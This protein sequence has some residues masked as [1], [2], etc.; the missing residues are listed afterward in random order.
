MSEWITTFDAVFFLSIGT[1]FVGLIGTMLKYC[2]KSKC[3]EFNCCSMVQGCSL[4]TVKRRVDLEVQEE[5]H[6]MD[7]RQNPTANTNNNSEQKQSE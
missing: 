4:F 5:L 7:T 1:L 6:E 2:I 3:E